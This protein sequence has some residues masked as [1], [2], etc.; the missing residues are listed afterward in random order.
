MRQS[1]KLSAAE[2]SLQAPPHHHHLRG[3]DRMPPFCPRKLGTGCWPGRAPL[4][5]A[6]W[7]ARNGVGGPA[8]SKCA[9]A[10]VHLQQQLLFCCT[11]LMSGTGPTI[12]LDIKMN[13][14]AMLAQA[15]GQ[16]CTANV[17]ARTL[18]NIPKS[19]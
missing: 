12:S 14:P 10:L 2:C 19:T 9:L 6:D 17:H 7:L 13:E 1:A 5:I 4:P 3:C 16:K 11:A 15:Q 18:L 8:S